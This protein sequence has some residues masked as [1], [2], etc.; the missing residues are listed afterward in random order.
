M[1]KHRVMQTTSS[2]AKVPAEKLEMGR[3]DLDE[4]AV[5]RPPQSRDQVLGAGILGQE[6]DLCRRR[7][8]A[9]TGS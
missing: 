1:T 8:T 9:G 4:A 5:F 7:A 2:A 6:L 3:R